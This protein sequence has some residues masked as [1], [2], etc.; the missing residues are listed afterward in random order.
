MNDEISRNGGPA[1]RMMFAALFALW[2][3]HCIGCSSEQS[4]TATEPDQTSTGGPAPTATEFRGGKFDASGV[5]FVPGTDQVLIVDN[6][7]KDAVVAMPVDAQG[8]QVGDTRSVPLGIKV[9]DPEDITTDGNYFYV[10]GSQSKPKKRNDIGLARFK[11][12]ASGTAS[13]VQAIAGFGDL[14]LQKLPELAA[15]GSRDG[16]DDGLN[17]EGL[18][19][20][21]RAGRLLLGLRSPFLKAHA[22]IIPVTLPGPGQPFNAGAVE[23]GDPI[24]LPLRGLGIRAIEYIEKLNAY[25]II[26]GGTETEKQAEFQLWRWDGEGQPEM[27]E[28]LERKIR[29]EGLTEVRTGGSDYIFVVADAGY[30]FRLDRP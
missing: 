10:V 21:P 4:K 30:Y 23:V 19:W 28:T 18:A 16:A 22:V 8:N 29:P 5:V 11:Y 15:D 27:I 26:A 25:L 9:D 17:I 14:I 13:D 20:D 6:N 7:L 24:T 3:L 12:D 2:T 1:V